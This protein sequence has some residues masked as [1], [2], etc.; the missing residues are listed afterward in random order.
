MSYAAVLI[1]AA[2]FLAT[3][4]VAVAAHAGVWYEDATVAVG[5]DVRIA[6]ELHSPEENFWPAFPE[7]MGSG[8]CLADFNGD[9]LPDLYV[10]NQDFNANNVHVGAWAAKVDP[11][12]KLYVNNGDGTLRDA[13]LGSGADLKGFGYGCSAADYDGDSDLDL[14][15]TGFGVLALLANDG[16]ATFT[17]VT[18]ASGVGPRSCGP[19]ACMSTSSAWADYDGDGDLDA[20]V[21]NYL[22]TNLTDN[23]RGPLNHLAQLNWLFR[24]G[25][26]GTFLE[27][28]KDLGVAGRR[29][30]RNGSKSLGVTWFDAERDGDFDLYVLN[31]EEPNEYYENRGD[32]T[33]VDRSDASRLADR[34]GSMGIATQDYDGDGFQDLFFS[35]YAD[36]HNG[37]YR[38]LH[39][40]TFEDRSG[41]DDLFNS[42]DTV[43]WGTAFVDA[44]RDMDLDI[45]LVNGHTEWALED[46]N[47]T[48]QV[49]L[50]LPNGSPGAASWD[51]NWTDF[52]RHAGPGV[53][54]RRVARGAAFG[55]FDL[56]GD[57]DWVIV[58][59]ANQS[60]EF[61]RASRVTNNYLNV[62]LR[63]PGMNVHGI[64]AEVVVEA[65]GATER[66]F[67]QAGA[68]YL[69]QNAMAA[70]FGLA[71]HPTAESVTVRWP[72]G[73]T[74]VVT[75][76]PVN[77]TIRIDRATG[78]YVTDPIAPRTRAVIAGEPGARGW[79]HSPVTVAL[80]AAD[81]GAPTPSGLVST[82][83][84]LEGGAWQPYDGRTFAF[85][86][87]THRIFG[88]SADA[89]GNVEPRR[90]FR[91]LVDLTAPTASHA[92]AGVAGENGWFVSANVTVALAG[93]DAASGIAEIAYRLD[94]GAWTTYAG[95]FKISSD[96]AHA[97]DYQAFDVAGNA[98]AIERATVKLD[99]TAPDV[100]ITSPDIGNVYLGAR[101][102]ADLVTGPA[103]VVATPGVFG[104][105]G[106]TF[107]ARAAASDAA[108]GVA[109]V[110]F[111][112]NF[113]P[114]HTDDAGPDWTWSWD[115][116]PYPGGAYLMN[117]TAFDAAGNAKAHGLRVVLVSGT[118]EGAAATAT[119]GPSRYLGVGPVDDAGDDAALL[120][121]HGPSRPRALA[122]R[123]P[124]PGRLRRSAACA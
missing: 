95:P 90:T 59:N 30:D 108:S 70:E 123:S 45:L 117:A 111:A 46:Y 33:F 76:V 71:R 54:E 52:T 60:V 36:E 17:D 120:P 75:G 86:E 47:Q 69:S 32:G 19:A 82:E 15:V 57:T 104:L 14:L 11:R 122:H 113:R 98:G 66:L 67:V 23:R 99:H 25:G 121:R 97:L 80:A 118:P 81:Q 114:V 62:L 43:G 93:S 105:G 29:L 26:D 124:A 13:S 74:T 51:R 101:R 1:P 110:V 44:D 3:A 55:D 100:T 65:G 37:F 6:G 49:Y 102:V 83:F 2:A 73:V 21:A 85:G 42:F 28:A 112:M 88:R 53:T 94:G 5:V 77:R 16:D 39:N 40:G 35:H 10:V 27:V 8:A 12:S 72:D 106:S 34:R 78:T 109:R 68:S 20:F 103:Y 63:Q 96:G 22:D 7:I 64:G 87:G 48:A 84:A 119:G 89:A 107:P 92:L 50:S 116:R 38:N 41:E 56:D 79:W 91:V 9:A 18:R 115:T 31:D 4:G 61:L 24:N 58:P